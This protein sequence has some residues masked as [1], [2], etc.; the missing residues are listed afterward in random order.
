M[1]LTALTDA[2]EIAAAYQRFA[3]RLRDGAT[4]FNDLVVGWQGESR[5]MDIY[6]Q[7]T[8]QVWG[9]PVE[10][11]Y[12]WFGFGTDD[13]ALKNAVG[14]IVV[15]FGFVKQGSNR[16]YAGV[17]AR[18]EH[19]A[20]H[21][22]HSGGIGGGYPG[23]G[24]TAFLDAYDGRFAN[25]Y[26]VKPKAKVEYIQVGSLDDPQLMEHVAGFVRKVEKFKEKVR[27]GAS[28]SK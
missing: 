22:L 5:T 11:D 13:P 10:E 26:W 19:G 20:L 6:W 23:I 21:L 25:V 7:P 24:K 2:D 17:F 9:F 1:P 12:Y 27:S 4:V 18:D 8:A 28:G 16:Q 14:N 3:Q 15:Q